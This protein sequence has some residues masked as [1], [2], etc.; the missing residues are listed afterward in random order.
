MFRNYLLTT[1]RSVRRQGLFTF[2]NISSLSIGLGCA[3]LI[4]LYVNDELSFDRFHTDGDRIFRVVRYMYEPDGSVA[5]TDPA[6]PM[7][8]G[9]AIKND[10]P[11]V[12]NYTRMIEEPFYVRKGD[13]SYEERILIA[14]PSLTE[15]FS[16]EMVEGNGL[17][18]PE[19]ILISE[20]IAGKFFGEESPVGQ[21]ISIRTQGVWNEFLVGGVFKDVPSNSSIQFELVMNFGKLPQLFPFVQGNESNWNM[22]AFETYILLKENSSIEKLA[23]QMPVF[24]QKYYPDEIETLREEGRWEGE[25]I[26]VNYILQPLPDLHLTPEIGGA[27]IPPTN[28]R[29]LWIISLIGVILL[30][31]ACINFT[32]LA[33]GRSTRRALEIGLRK[34]IGASRTQLRVQFLGEAFLLTFVALLMGIVMA[35]LLLPLFNQLSGK[36]LVFASLFTPQSMG[37]LIGISLLAGLL[38]GI[39]PAVILSNFNPVEVL[40]NK[41]KL[42]GA[43]IFTNSLVVIQFTLSIILMA[44]TFIIACQI[45][46]MKGTHLGYDSEHVIVIPVQSLDGDQLLDRYRQLSDTW[47]DI[48]MVSGSNVSFTRG[49]TRVGYVYEQKVYEPHFFRIDHN[50]LNTLGLTLKDGRNFDA[51]LSTDTLNAVMI[52]ESMA[53]LLGWENPAGKVLKG[54]Q[55][56]RS[57]MQDPMIIGVLKDYHVQSLQHEIPPAVLSLEPSIPY[58][59]ILVRVSNAHIPEILDRLKDTWEAYTAEIPFEYS[60]L[61]EDINQQYAREERWGKIVGYASLLTI[62]VACMGLFGLS[63]IVVAGRT[64]EIGIR[65]VLGAS[66]RQIVFLLSG[67]LGKLVLIALLI[68]TPITWFAAEEW[69]MNFPYRINQSFLVFLATGGVM[70]FIAVLTVSFNSIRAATRNPV[71]TLRNE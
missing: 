20:T 14:D 4:Y 64:R 65:K 8:L 70:I 1:I 29:Y 32:T 59:F 34:V 22:S 13:K 35:E 18:T 71:E 56:A 27:S 58:R 31:I 28:P 15:V 61:D 54:F 50:Y 3:A 2:I 51:N 23:D 33:I 6:L 21:S 48:E 69:L 55:R 24:R 63:A 68:G 16:F 5:S 53:R 9:P 37:I 62:L 7:P 45:N 11:E 39:Y 60:F 10:F 67:Q 36:S 46:Y 42:G 44:G 17:V 52:N 43:N 47:P 30:V 25:G 40:K 66:V 49:R 57:G 41:L 19:Q 26:P 38:A 12:E